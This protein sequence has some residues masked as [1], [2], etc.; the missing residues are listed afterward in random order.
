MIPLPWT[1]QPPDE[2]RGAAIAVGNFDGVHAGHRFL[3]KLLRKQADAIGGP[4]VVVTFEPH[5]LKLLRPSA[6]MPVLTPAADRVALI[7]Q[8]AIDRVWLLHTTEDLLRLSAQEFFEEVLQ[9][10]LQARALVEGTSFHFGRDRAGD[11]R[12]LAELC[13]DANIVLS[14]VPPF[15]LAGRPVSSSRVRAALESGDVRAAAQLLERPYRLRGTVARGAQ[16]GRGLGFP[17]ANLVDTQSLV[18]AEG[19]YAV[20]VPLDEK[21]WPGAANIGPNPTFGDLARKVEVH[22]I[23]FDGDL[24]G[25]S[26][27]MDFIERLRGVQT[28]TSVNELAE[29][30]QRDV[31]A[32]RRLAQ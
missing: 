6:F 9:K 18:P 7:Q 20:R 2:F 4:A 30:I 1:T 15:E 3:F 27:E 5:P 26:L 28:F 12:L 17:T 11:V 10:R 19:V 16:R 29:Q 24:L 25:Q 31:D 14:V 23:G 22:L 32:A 13:R 8:C 21:T